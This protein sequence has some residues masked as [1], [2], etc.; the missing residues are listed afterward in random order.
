MLG[1]FVNRRGVSDNSAHVSLPL[2]VIRALADGGFSVVR[3][4][5]G[6]L[7]GLAVASLVACG[8]AKSPGPEIKFVIAEKV[9]TRGERAERLYAAVVKPRIESVQSFRVGGRIAA[10]LADVG[11]HVTQGQVLATLDANDWALN[12]QTVHGQLTAA[13]AQRD[14]ARADLARF[15]RLTGEKLMSA[16]ELDRQQHAVAAAVG[17]V[18]ALTAAA[19]EADNKLSYAKLRADADGVVTQVTAEPGQVVSE[20]TPVITIARTAERELEFSIPEQR[21]DSIRLGQTVQVSLWSEPTSRLEARVRW[22]APSA[23]VSTRAF[24]VRASLLVWP[25]SLLFGM[26]ASVRA[27]AD[28]SSD[29]QVTL[30]IAAVFDQGSAKAVWVVDPKAGVLRGAAVEVTALDGNRYV[31]RGLRPGDLVVTAGVHRLR[32]GDHVA[33]FTGGEQPTQLAAQH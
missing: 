28:A 30:P 2:S 13:I 12:A 11:D 23:D 24:P 1:R 32:A 7:A 3:I 16:A 9:S 5:M 21:R 27:P 19:R 8:R 20:G 33:V 18:A 31:V 29:A 26:T 4:I 25:Q 14:S 22:I 6:A 15:E 10:R 17:Q